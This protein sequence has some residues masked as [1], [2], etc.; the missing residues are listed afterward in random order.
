M[1]S[2]G[3]SVCLPPTRTTLSGPC[4]QAF[5]SSRTP[6]QPPAVGG[7]PLRLR[8]GINTGEAL[9]RL[10]VAAA[11]GEGFLTGD[12]INT[13]SRIQ[14]V[15]P[16]MGVA[17]GLATFEATAA[18]LRLRGARAGNAE[19]QVRAGAGLPCEGPARRSG[20]DVTRV[21]DTPFIGREIDLAI[22]KGVFD[23]SLAADS[24]QLVT[25]VGEPGLG[26]SRIV[27]ELLAYVDAKPDLVTWRQ[28]R[29]LPYGEGITFWALGEILKAHAGILESDTSDVAIAKFEAVL[30]DGDERAVVPPAAPSACSGSRPRP[31]RT[32]GA[33]HRVAPLPRAHRR[34]GP[35]RA[36]L[37]GPALGRRARCSRSSNTSPTARRGPSA[38]HRHG[39]AGAVRTPSRLRPPAQRDADQSHTPQRGGDRAT[40]LRTARRRPCSLFELQQP[41]LDRAGGNPLYAEEFVRLLKD[42]D[43]LTEKGTGWDAARRGR[44]AFPRLDPGADRRTPGHPRRRHEVDARRRRRRGEGLLGRRHRADGW[45]GPRRRDRDPP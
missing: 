40:R 21:H 19:G 11:S 39:T 17:V 38:H 41:I 43:L 30:P 44:G 25:V 18:G 9:V 36:R 42:K 28:G 16:E 13:A 31:G 2:S 22:L 3:S 15:A 33:V 27:A 35:H 26:K 10:G 7:A 14:S 12:S 1:R 23:K 20:T 37:R 4:A 34:G 32:R 29:C 8:V 5:G 24:P 45:A 6:R